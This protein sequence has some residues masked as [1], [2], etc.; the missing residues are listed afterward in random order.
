MSPNAVQTA[1]NCC[2]EQLLRVA[3]SPL[4][5]LMAGVQ[6]LRKDLQE[7]GASVLLTRRLQRQPRS[8]S[9]STS[10]G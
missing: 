5:M 4:L 6:A 7:N 3:A 9:K 10:C 1:R 8:T 2:S